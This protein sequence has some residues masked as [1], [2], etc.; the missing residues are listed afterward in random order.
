MVQERG[1]VGGVGDPVGLGVEERG[2][3]GVDE[4]VEFWAWEVGREEC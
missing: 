3:L 1:E 4:G 2:R